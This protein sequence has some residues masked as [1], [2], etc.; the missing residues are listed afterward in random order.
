MKP[1]VLRAEDIK[2]SVIKGDLANLTEDQ[3][4][5]WGVISSL[6]YFLFFRVTLVIFR[7]I[8]ATRMCCFDRIMRFMIRES[9]IL[10]RIIL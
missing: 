9:L 7:N 3:M 10:G 1:L 4:E 6:V 2:G 5:G 8:N